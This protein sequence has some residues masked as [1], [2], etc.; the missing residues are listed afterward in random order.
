MPIF[1][2][3][4]NGDWWEYRQG[5]TLHILNTDDL[6]VE[7]Q[8]DWDTYH[9]MNETWIAEYGTE[10]VHDIVL[11]EPP[12]VWYTDEELDAEVNEFLDYEFNEAYNETMEE[13]A[14]ELLV[15]EDALRDN[16]A[17]DEIVTSYIED[18]LTWSETITKIKDI[19]TGDNN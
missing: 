15:N 13:L 7:E 4:S 6:P 11:P 18:N 10:V 3:N 14:E 9:Q 1:I 8:A 16:G 19:L 5:E 17:I 2:A 12:K